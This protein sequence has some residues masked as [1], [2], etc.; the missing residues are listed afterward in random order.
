MCRS[1]QS[2]GT[3]VLELTKVVKTEYTP[4][5]T[6]YNNIKTDQEESGDRDVTEACRLSVLSTS[7]SNDLSENLVQLLTDV[8]DLKVQIN[9][10]ADEKVRDENLIKYVSIYFIVLFSN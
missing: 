5:P 2:H 4:T 7:K 6:E 10:F 3:S 9:Y 8:N 1:Q